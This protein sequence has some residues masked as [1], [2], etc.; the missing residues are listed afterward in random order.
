[1][2]V[3]IIDSLAE[4]QIGWRRLGMVC[5]LMGTNDAEPQHFVAA[6]H[7]MID[8]ALQVTCNADLE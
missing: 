6:V 3:Q 5:N 1:M 8:V 4:Q 7:Q 2:A